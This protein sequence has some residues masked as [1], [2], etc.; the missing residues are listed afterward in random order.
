MDTFPSKAH[1]E[2]EVT[3]SEFELGE[4][5]TREQVTPI[6]LQLG[7]RAFDLLSAYSL[8]DRTS[9]GAQAR[10]AIEA[11]HQHRLQD[12]GLPDLIE[13]AEKRSFPTAE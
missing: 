8:V 11:Y 13:R 12:P 2:I 5:R 7:A 3:P 6:S 9:V 10:A 1:C 4:V